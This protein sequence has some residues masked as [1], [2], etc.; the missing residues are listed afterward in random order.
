VPVVLPNPDI[1]WE[2]TKK[3]EFAL[4]LGLFKD[5]VYLVTNYYRNRSSNQL[6]FLSY[7]TQS[8]VNSLLANLPALIQNSGVE[9]ELSSTN[10]RGKD[11]KWTTAFNI[12]FPK[13]KLVDFPG[14]ASTFSANSYVVGMPLNFTRLYR[15]TGVDAA[16]GKATYEDI[17]K[18]GVINTNDRYIGKIGTPYFGGLSNSFTYKGLQ[19][20]LFFQ[21][22]HRFGHLY[23][24]GGGKR[25]KRARCSLELQPRRVRPSLPLT[26][27]SVNLMPFTVTLPLSNSVQPVLVTPCRKAG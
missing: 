15:Y 2:T 1:Q 5:R 6:T 26:P 22:N 9:V 12:T 17:D 11:F 18:N 14:L 23:L 4:E 21:F 16:T 24:I 27:N 8:G 3:M 10:L 25:A 13:N 7:P 20:D 19:L